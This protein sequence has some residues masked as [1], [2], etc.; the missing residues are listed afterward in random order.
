MTQG[1]STVYLV[2]EVP[3]RVEWMEMR[4]VCE[5]NRGPE[6]ELYKC[7][8]R[9]TIDNEGK[10]CDVAWVNLFELDKVYKG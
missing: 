2:S 9:K 4:L 6:I 5:V 7:E 1:P 10:V 3:M 8:R